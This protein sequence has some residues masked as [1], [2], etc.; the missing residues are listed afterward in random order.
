M[1][2]RSMFGLDHLISGLGA[3]GGLLVVV[4]VA[5]LLG[6][7]HATDPDHLVAVSTLLATESERP[8]RRATRLG[9]A[10]GLG[11][12]SSLVV[13]GVPVVL[14]G[15]RVPGPVQQAAEV[16]VGLVIMALAVR[17]VGH[18]RRGGFHAHEHR[19]DGVPHRHLHGHCHGNAHAH[20]HRLPRSETQACVIGVIHGASGSG[21]I[22]V[23]LLAS[24]GSRG[25]AVAA[26]AVFAAGT[27]LSMTVLSLGIG[28]AFA[29]DRARYRLQGLA[30]AFAPIS[31]AF[32]AWWAA[33]AIQT[34][35]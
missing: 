8:A 21:A 2:A 20:D 10:W 23:L 26:L 5:L 17:L 34:A 27:A 16:V 19:H 12:A 25:A 13:L 6:L 7:R 33:A 24:I 9:L 22:V 28:Y 14:L 30:P 4:G 32:G 29:R 3:D 35:V 15:E 1:G 11:H 31:F 18:W